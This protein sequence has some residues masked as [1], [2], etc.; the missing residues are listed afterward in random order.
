MTE[1]IDTVAA[2]GLPGALLVYV[3]VRL[4]AKMDRLT[5]TI[6][7]LAVTVAVSNGENPDELRKYIGNGLS[8]GH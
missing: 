5:R 8:G 7:Y 2:L 3:L 1:W 4:E 6:N